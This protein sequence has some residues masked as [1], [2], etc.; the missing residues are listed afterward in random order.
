MAISRPLVRVWVSTEGR[1]NSGTGSGRGGD[2]LNLSC[3]P[4][5][6]GCIRKSEKR[7]KKNK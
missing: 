1:D 6:R 3:E 5:G 4:R 7:E 2:L